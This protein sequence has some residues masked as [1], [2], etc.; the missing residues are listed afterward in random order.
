[1]HWEILSLYTYRGQTEQM[2]YII[3]DLEH[4]QMVITIW[5]FLSEQSTTY[6]KQI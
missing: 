1:M 2:E 3:I 6:S 4:I 5:Y